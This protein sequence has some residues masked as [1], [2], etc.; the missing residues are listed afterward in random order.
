MSGD[1]TQN[2]RFD[3][4]LLRRRGWISPSD[5]EERL[6]ALPDVSEKG[7]VV[8]PE[9]ATQGDSESKDADS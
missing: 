7:E 3:R 1:S 5:L 4:R 6:A 8:Q 9:P 2:L